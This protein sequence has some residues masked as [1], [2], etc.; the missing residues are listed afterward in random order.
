M[1][2][3]DKAT[4]AAR[5]RYN[6]IAPLH[7]FIEGL[8][9]GGHS[10]EWRKLLWSKVEGTNLLEVGVGTGN[11]FP[12]YPRDTEITA[13]DLS[14]KMLKLARDKAS[15]QKVK[16]LLQRMDVQDLRFEGNT[17]DTVVASFVFCTIPNPVRGLMEIQRVCRVGG[18]VIL[19]EHVLSSNR[20]VSLLM[21]LVNPIITQLMRENINRQ[22]V[23]NVNKSG[24]V[25]EQVTDLA[26]GIF[27][28][29]E[30]RKITSQE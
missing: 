16:V 15:Q 20:I 18:E 25:V 12:Y 14:E 29:I 5:K 24:L 10:V 1:Y 2:T 4:K 21:N 13:V 8:M 3:K 6:C 9:G 27:K 26:A 11:N 19:L 23:E 30:S 7:D 28:L 22:T 17:F